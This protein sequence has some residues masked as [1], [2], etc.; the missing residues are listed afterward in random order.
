MNVLKLIMVVETRHCIEFEAQLNTEIVNM[1][2]ML[3]A[4]CDTQYTC[5]DLVKES[6]SRHK[7]W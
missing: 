6:A 3:H 5:F 2:A 1:G 4:H 7:L